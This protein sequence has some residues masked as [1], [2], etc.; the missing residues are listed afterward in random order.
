MDVF[1]SFFIAV[2]SAASDGRMDDY[3]ACIFELNVSDKNNHM[4]TFG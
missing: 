1:F 3:G 2:R 4:R